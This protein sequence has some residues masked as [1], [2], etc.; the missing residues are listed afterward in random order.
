MRQHT[1]TDSN[2]Y[3]EQSTQP[4]HCLVFVAPLLI[5]YEVGIIWLGPSAMRNG[6]DIWLREFLSHLGFGQYFFL[7][8]VT[9]GL[10]LG[11]HHVTR[12]QWRLFPQV[13]SGMT[14]ESFL[15][16]LSIVVVGQMAG[17]LVWGTLTE[18]IASVSLGIGST[19]P[20]VLSFLGAGIYEELLFRLILL[21]GSIALFQQLGVDRTS[22]W[23]AAIVA[24]SLLFAAAHYRMFFQ[25]GLE[26]TWYSFLF[27]GT[28]GVVFSFLY[29]YRGFG[30]AVGTHAV[31][32]I[33]VTT[34]VA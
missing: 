29:L 19:L 30:I 1:Q 25:T 10:L 21:S 16:G 27:R 8:L 31:Y 20:H 14:C 15:V 26:F 34:F 18:D 6:A 22:A 13:L 11:W 9:C 3:W 33:L 7:P 24:T 17:W 5:L 12:C 4:L 23:V 2:A 28:A 32:D